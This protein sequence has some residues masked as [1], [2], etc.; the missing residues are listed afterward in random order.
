MH[1]VGCLWSRAVMM[2]PP[3][4]S[5]VQLLY[6]IWTGVFDLDALDFQFLLSS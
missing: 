3:Q 6:M 2:R 1:Q 5:V 4:S